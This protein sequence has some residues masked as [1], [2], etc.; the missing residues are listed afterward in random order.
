MSRKCQRGGGTLNNKTRRQ[1]KIL[2]I[3][4]VLLCISIIT[5]ISY[6][7]WTFTVGQ[8]GTNTVQ[9]DCLEIQLNEISGAINLD[10]ARPLLDKDGEKTTPYTFKLTNTC[11]LEVE[12][13]INLEVLEAENRIASKNIAVKVDTLAKTILSSN[14]VVTPTSGVDAYSLYTGRL[15]P[16]A[17]V[18]HEIRLWLDESAGNDSQNKT[19]NSKV[20]ISTQLAPLAY[21]ETTLNGT[22][23]VLEGDLVPVIISDTGVV[24]KANTEE[25]WYNYNQKK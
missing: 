4:G 20:V 25:E 15:K 21:K 13:N 10:K 11:G 19:F 6:A 1:N 8:T 12:Y 22:D 24:T 9:A 2:I 18:T 23:S 7:W 14:K 16:N 3:T 5:G 17:N